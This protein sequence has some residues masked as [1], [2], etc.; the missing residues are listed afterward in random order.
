MFFDETFISFC[1]FLCNLN[2]TD[3]AW[4]IICIFS[5]IVDVFI[6]FWFC[7]LLSAVEISGKFFLVFKVF[8]SCATDNLNSFD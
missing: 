2:V 1:Y 4:R 7:L 5:N 6:L 3:L 8:N